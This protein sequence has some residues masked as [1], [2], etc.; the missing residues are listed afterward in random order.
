[1]FW[2]RLCVLTNL[3]QLFRFD[4]FLGEMINARKV[5]I[6]MF[7]LENILVIRTVISVYTSSSCIPVVLVLVSILL[8]QH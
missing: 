5:H 2:Q 6:I 4:K 7:V 3:Y 1:M 8:F